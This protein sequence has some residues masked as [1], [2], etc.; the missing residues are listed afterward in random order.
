MSH[1]KDIRVLSS[2]VNTTTCG[3]CNQSIDVSGKEPFSVVVCPQCGRQEKVPVVFGQFLLQDLLSSGGM[4][5]VYRARDMNLGRLVAIKVMRQSLGEDQEFVNRFRQ[6]AQAAAQLNHPSIAQIYTFGQENGQPYIAMEFVAGRKFD[7]LIED[8]RNGLDPAFVLR[9]GIEIAEGLKAA[10]EIGLIH[11]DIKPGNILLDEKHRAKLVDFG[12]ASYAGR[13]NEGGVWGT[14]Y[15]I[16]PEIIQKQKSDARSDIY[17]LGATLFH[18]LA[19]RPPFEGQTPA[20]VVALRLREEAPSLRTFLPA[21]KSE[22]ETTIARMLQMHAAKRYPSYPSLISDLKAALKAVTDSGSATGRRVVRLQ[23]KKKGSA[24]GADGSVGPQTTSRIVEPR[25]AVSKVPDLTLSAEQER[26]AE[27]ALR[28]SRVKRFLLYVL[29]IVLVV[30]LSI[31]GFFFYRHYRAKQAAEMEVRRQLV[32]LRQARTEALDLAGQVERVSD[33]IGR[34]GVGIYPL[35][36]QVSNVLMSVLGELPPE[37]VEEVTVTNQ[38]SA[39]NEAAEVPAPEPEN[40]TPEQIEAA[41]LRTAAGAAHAAGLQM[42]RKLKAVEAAAAEAVVAKQGA[43]AAA[44]ANAVKPFTGKL[45]ELLASVRG[46][47][48]E[49]APLIEQA[50][51]AVEAAQKQKRTIERIRNAR[52]AEEERQRREEAQK[53]LVTEELNRAG[54]LAS[55]VEQLVKQYR[56]DEAAKSVEKELASYKSEE[57]RKAA[58]AIV[59]RYRLAAGLFSFLIEKLN[60]EPFLWGWER[61]RGVY[62]DVLG[63]D[64]NGVKLRDRRVPWLKISLP[65]IMRF[66]DR[67]IPAE[68]RLGQQGRLYMGVAVFLRELGQ[69][70]SARRYVEKAIAAAPY[71][72]EQAASIVPLQ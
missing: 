23:I 63:A 7:K 20:E 61:S 14:P 35:V 44:D 29:L 36:A 37:P 72:G 69:T 66:V 5:G 22:V 56:F 54:N 13:R 42:T 6:E 38:P 39:T 11:G 43:A 26:E 31:G 64:Q 34:F 40:Q 12:I 21:V 47:R 57:G 10:D 17:S 27:A 48:A 50:Q 45:T 1:E 58:E 33:E 41:A 46:I 2:P 15:Y 70:E 62:E 25:E 53:A 18:A 49:I 65:Q 67:Y 52:A 55:S 60:A 3:G 30:G 51:T 68:P 8:A 9:V 4:G 32:A 28:W 71:L 16:A 24:A 59:E 19:G